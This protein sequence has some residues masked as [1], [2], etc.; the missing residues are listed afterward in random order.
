M[1]RQSR[2]ARR[3]THPY[4]SY[5]ADSKIRCT[6]CNTLLKSDAAWGS[7]LHSSQHTLR[8]TRA[9]EAAAIR[10]GSSAGQKRKA[11]SQSSPPPEDR[12]KAKSVTF[13]AGVEEVDDTAGPEEAPSM[14]YPIKESEKIT[15][16]SSQPS[17]G[18]NDQID[19]VEM[20][21]FERELAEMEASMASAAADKATISAP[22]MTAADIAAQA[23]E[24]QSAQRGKREIELEAERDDAAKM[25]ED[26]FDE[27]E[28]L[29]ERVRRLRERREE[30]KKAKGMAGEAEEIPSATREDERPNIDDGQ[31]DEDGDGDDDDDD[32][33]V[34]EWAFGAR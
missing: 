25:L 1:L 9:Q 12:K 32:E 18:N 34:D 5:T 14:D 15:P 26:E 13:A 7:H 31:A 23:R 3:I 19:P 10:A 30:L 11:E 6:L 28:G 20:E 29:E 33:D 2:E 22:A 21:A 8:Q 24:E 27:M 17:S 16:S 4:A